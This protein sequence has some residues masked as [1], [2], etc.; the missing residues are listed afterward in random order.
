MGGMGQFHVKAHQLANCCQP[1][2]RRVGSRARP[3]A[4]R[5]APLR[6]QLRVVGGLLIL[7]VA[8]SRSAQ[9][10]AISCP[11]RRASPPTEQG[12]PYIGR[13]NLVGLPD[14]N[15]AGGA[16]FGSTLSEPEQ[17]PGIR[18][19]EIGASAAS[20]PLAIQ[21]GKEYEIGAYVCA[22]ATPSLMYI[23]ADFLDAQHKKLGTVDVG[24][25]G[26][27]S[28]N[29]WERVFT[30]VRAL[31]GAAYARIRLGRYPRNPTPGSTFDRAR[32]LV[33]DV[34]LKA[35]EG[36]QIPTKEQSPFAGDWVGVTSV[37]NLQLLGSASKQDF[38]PLC[39]YGSPNRYALYSRQGFN[40][41]M[42]SP[43]SLVSIAQAASARS[44]YN[45]DG[46]RVFLE[47]TP[48][49]ARESPLFMDTTRLS[50]ELDSL[51]SSPLHKAVAGFY[52]D[53][54]QYDEHHAPLVITDQIK[55]HDTDAK[56]HRRL[57]IIALEG[58]V[59]RARLVASM[60]DGVATYA[61]ASVFRGVPQITTDE[62]YRA[63]EADSTQ[64]LPATFAVISEAESAAEVRA[65]VFKGLIAGARG[66][67]YYRD[68][69]C[70]SEYDGDRLGVGCGDITMRG[71]WAAIP[72]LRADFDRLGN[73]L[74]LPVGN[75]WSVTSSGEA[76]AVGTRG[77]RCDP[78]VIVF[79]TEERPAETT[80]EF[81]GVTTQS[82]AEDL[83]SGTQ[84]PFSSDS[85]HIQLG[86]NQAMVLRPLVTRSGPQL[87][88]QECMKR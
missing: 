34:Y 22:D 35:T 62:R 80:I 83:L 11:L 8:T 46:L 52:W 37:G 53:D 1:V 28:P 9:A 49:L 73:V 72:E 24:S 64:L 48:Y 5:H 43:L 55:L 17:E 25:Q 23:T 69:T 31:P 87:G 56:G 61:R 66:F 3:I 54:E 27:T 21:S 45:P 77:E 86:P 29:R 60:A 2:R 18:L 47:V 65:L 84:I 51:Y 7:A 78:I 70:T 63:L 59:G 50:T 36:S 85:L 68:G 19:S 38:F 67:A 6:R 75:G 79:N 76:I 44:I 71:M 41:V 32:V 82:V 74:F 42:R 81:H 14:W 57:P 12:A 33:D 40:C 10:Q 15:L 58:Q 88:P 4:R 13:V 26:I 39:V 20:P 30:F 16:S